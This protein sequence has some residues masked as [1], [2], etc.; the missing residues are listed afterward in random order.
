MLKQLLILSVLSF[1]AIS[2]SKVSVIDLVQK[3]ASAKKIKEAIQKGAD[4]NEVSVFGNTALLLAIK[5]EC[6]KAISKVLI[7]AGADVNAT[8]QR[9]QSILM[10]ASYHGHVA[11]AKSLIKA[12]ADVNAKGFLFGQTALMNAAINKKPKIVKLLLK[13]GAKVNARDRYRQTALYYAYEEAYEP[14][15]NETD[16]EDTIQTLIRAGGVEHLN[17]Y[18]RYRAESRSVSNK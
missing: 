13:S 6:P 10:Y 2:E 1:S 5:E 11:V 4:V 9:G 7:Q 3:N 15:D 16:P 17:R 12:G 14:L 8:D 18:K